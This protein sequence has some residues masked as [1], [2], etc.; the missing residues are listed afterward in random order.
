MNIEETNLHGEALRAMSHEEYQD[1]EKQEEDVRREREIEIN[2]VKIS[3]NGDISFW[4]LDMNSDEARETGADWYTSPCIETSNDKDFKMILDYICEVAKTESNPYKVFVL[5]EKFAQ[6]LEKA[7]QKPVDTSTTAMDAVMDEIAAH[8]SGRID[9]GLP[10]TTGMR[11]MSH[12][13][14]QDYKKSQQEKGNWERNIEINGVEITVADGIEFW[15]IDMDSDEAE[16]SGANRYAS[17]VIYVSDDEDFKR[18]LDYVCELAKTE[19]NPYK[20]F[21][22]GVTYANKLLDERRRPR[23]QEEIWENGG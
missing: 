20:V 10:I 2:G 9:D 17:P 22:Q 8:G 15:Q 21:V 6:E 18:T 3:V 1:W 5:G 16:K 23:T 7:H 12:E 19:S 13:E 11:A 14:Y 4:Q